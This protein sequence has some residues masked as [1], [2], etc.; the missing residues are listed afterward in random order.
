MD[1]KLPRSVIIVSKPSGP[2]HQLYKGQG[3]LPQSDIHSSDSTAL[4]TTVLHS[5][6]HIITLK[7]S[8]FRS[9]IVLQLKPQSSAIFWYQPSIVYHGSKPLSVRYTKPHPSG[10]V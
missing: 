3:H 1:S 2:C 8:S 6:F 10:Q 5:I 4:Q 7:I 9:L